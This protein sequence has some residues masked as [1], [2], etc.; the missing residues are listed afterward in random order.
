[1]SNDRD[2]A[3]AFNEGIEPVVDKTPPAPE[4]QSLQFESVRQSGGLGGWRVAGIAAALVL[5]IGAGSLLLLGQLGSDES[6]G[7]VADEVPIVAADVGSIEGVWIL[8]SWEEGGNR[9]MVEIGENAVDDPWIEFTSDRYNGWTGCNAI[10]PAAYEYSAGFLALDETMVQAVGCEPGDA[11]EVL[12]T[13]LWKTPDGIEVI[14]GDDRMEW[15]GS[16]LEGLTYPLVFRR[17]EVS[18]AEPEPD[19]TPTTTT[20]A[21]VDGLATRVYDVDG[22]EVVTPSLVPDLPDRATTVEFHTMVIDSGDGPEL[23]LGGVNDSLPPQCGG[24]VASGL[25][26]DGWAETSQGVR[27]GE[28]SVIV[29]WPPVD[30][31]VEVV[32]QT[33][34]TPPFVV[35]LPGELPAVCAEAELGAGV[36]AIHEYRQSLGELDG[37]VYLANDGTL[38]LQ[39]VGDPEPHREAL[40]EIGGACV[41]EVARTAAQQRAIQESIDLGDLPDEIGPYASSTGPGGRVDIYVPVAD[42]ATAELI[43]GLV[44]DPT[45]IRLIGSGVLQP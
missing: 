35:Y 31:V 8:E 43:A 36:S 6:S 33:E 27:W 2:I 24:P 16:N 26:M 17:A 29:S 18:L 13:M 42:R 22:I 30:G 34:F 32:S 10:R 38:V 4:W 20:T 28:R 39:V 23:C 19:E 14:L 45:A 7:E 25:D 11:E 40:A 9:V 12:L 41:I 21:A 37:D 3:A 1:M 5:L 44:D 15:F